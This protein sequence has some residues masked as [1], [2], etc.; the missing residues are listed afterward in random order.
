LAGRSSPLTACTGEPDVDWLDGGE[1]VCD[2]SDG[3]DRDWFS[4]GKLEETWRAIVE[5]FLD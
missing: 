5:L 2:W 1:L 4:E 3:V